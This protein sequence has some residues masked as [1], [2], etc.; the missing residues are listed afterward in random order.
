[1][2][3]EFL[4]IYSPY[5]RK[6]AIYG[7]FLIVGLVIA[8]FL[9][10][11]VVY[12]FVTVTIYLVLYVT[13]LIKYHKTGVIDDEGLLSL[14]TITGTKFTIFMSWLGLIPAVFVWLW[15]LRFLLSQYG[16]L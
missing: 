12:V 1:M 14:K 10:Y 11:A 8:L 2:M 6:Q 13:I 5:F 9:G 4:K 15:L 16:L 3:K 7:L